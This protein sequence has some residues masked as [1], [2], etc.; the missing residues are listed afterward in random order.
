MIPYTLKHMQPD[1]IIDYSFKFIATLVDAELQMHLAT[2]FL[3]LHATN[4]IFQMEKREM[5]MGSRLL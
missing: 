2:F 5:G 3:V 1:M 4:L